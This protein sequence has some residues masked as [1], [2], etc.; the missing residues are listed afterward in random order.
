VGKD[1]EAIIVTE[2]PYQVNKA[3]WIMSIARMVREKEIEGITDIRDES[4]REGTRV[5]IDIRRG[6]NSQVILNHL[7]ARTQLQV[8]FGIINLAIDNGRPRLF[9]LKDMI[10]A[11]VDHRRDVVTRRSVFELAKAEA[12]AHILEGLTIALQNIDAVVE[13]IKKAASSVEA[14]LGLKQS[15]GLSDLQS[16]AI[17][18]MRLSRLTALETQKLYDELEVLRPKLHD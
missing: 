10:Q 9:N 5:V 16:Q 4:A 7:Y 13:I 1:K 11:F 3:D 15:F 14:K 8:S 2:L 6:E 12:R 18:D 17:L